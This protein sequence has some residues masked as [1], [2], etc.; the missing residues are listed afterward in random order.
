MRRGRGVPEVGVG[1]TRL[2]SGRE[3]EGR[4]GIW[5]NFGVRAGIYILFGKELELNGKQGKG[6]GKEVR[7]CICRGDSMPLDTLPHTSIDSG[8]TAQS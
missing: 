1:G 5:F 2:G 8:K 4:K 3:R 6:I 7:A